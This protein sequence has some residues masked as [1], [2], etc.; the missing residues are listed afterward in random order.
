VSRPPLKVLYLIDKLQRAGAQVHLGQLAAGLDPAR[1]APRVCS[2]IQGGP[3]AD[4]LERSGSTVE[5]LGLGTL[6]GP[7]GVLGLLRLARRLRR[8]RIQV[9]HSY[10]VSANVFGT[11]AARLARVPAVL[12]SR[13]DVGF[14][15]NWRL[16]VVEER[17]INPLVDR[18]TANSP[19]VAAAVSREPGLRPDKV[20]LIPNGVDVDRCDPERYDAPAIRAALG[21]AREERVVGSV[22][23]LSPVKGHADLLRAAGA[24]VR[25]G[26][27]LRVLLIG[28]GP[29]RGALQEQARTSGIAE[30]V[31]FAGVQEDVPRHLA[32]LDVFALPSHTEGMSNALLEAMAMARPVV[33]TA[34]DGNADVVEDGVT[35]RLVPP[36]TPDALA[37][38]LDDLFGEPARARELGREAR[39]RVASRYSLPLMVSRYEELYL[40]LV[41]A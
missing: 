38:A 37:R 13:R 32:A 30:R 40:S 18:V 28:D 25:K 10:L 36:R 20:V 24:L 17:L 5:C 23:H 26:A 31:T 41:P 34:V 11:L 9:V 3:V 27:P 16:R 6:Y 1:F 8:A 35:G 12:T 14:S 29:L 15:R 4:A 7:R 39:R 22:G 19:S 33:A 21:I 2:L